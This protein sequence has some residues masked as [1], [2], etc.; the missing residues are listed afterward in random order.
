M[1]GELQ[2]LKSANVDYIEAKESYVFSLV[3]KPIENSVGINIG[4]CCAVLIH[5]NSIAIFAGGAWGL[6]LSTE[7]ATTTMKA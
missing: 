1:T 7:L 3:A 4:Y 2:H 5:T 6:P